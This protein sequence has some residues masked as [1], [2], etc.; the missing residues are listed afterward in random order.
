MMEKLAI[1]L[2]SVK[3]LAPRFGKQERFMLASGKM[4]DNMVG[5]GL[6]MR[7]GNTMRVTFSMI[8]RMV[9]ENITTMMAL[10]TKATLVTIDL[11]VKA[12]KNT[13]IILLLKANFRMG[14]RS[15]EFLLGLMAQNT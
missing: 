9:K 8:K 14:K 15:R 11:K 4:I 6:F 12:S 3:D 1:K 5:E 10:F 7:M 2:I 13:L